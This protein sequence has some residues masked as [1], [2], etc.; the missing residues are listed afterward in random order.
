MFRGFSALASWAAR[1]RA[2]TDRP[3]VV[4]AAGVVTYQGQPI[5]ARY[6]HCS[7]TRRLEPRARPRPTALADL[8]FSTF[9]KDDGVA[10]AHRWFAIQRVDVIDKT[11]PGVDLSAGGKLFPPKSIGSFPK[12]FRPRQVG[13]DGRRLR[14]GR[15]SSSLT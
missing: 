8:C 12:V 11:P 2:R 4:P 6:G 1:S 10:L 7:A 13:P 15:T 3:K 9:G 14:M 5:E